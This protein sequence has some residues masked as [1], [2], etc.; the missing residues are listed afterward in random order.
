MFSML[1]IARFL[2]VFCLF[3]LYGEL[4]I[5]DSFTGVNVSMDVMV[6]EELKNSGNL[7]LEP[8][9]VTSIPLTSKI[10]EVYMVAN[11]HAVRYSHSVENTLN[12]YK[13]S[14]R[15]KVREFMPGEL[16]HM[17][18][19]IEHGS[20][21]GEDRNLFLSFRGEGAEILAIKGFE[22]ENWHL[23]GKPG[24]KTLIT[25]HRILPNVP[26]NYRAVVSFR[27]VIKED[28]FKITNQANQNIFLDDIVL[29]NSREAK[30]QD[31]SHA[32]Y[33]L[34]LKETSARLFYPGSTLST[35]TFFSASNIHQTD[36]YFFKPEFISPDGKV[37]NPDEIANPD[38]ISQK[39]S[40]N[41]KI[42]DPDFAKNK[43]VYYMRSLMIPPAIKKLGFGNWKFRVV[44]GIKGV[45]SVEKVV[46][47]R[48][49]QNSSP[50]VN[51]SHNSY[52]KPLK[53]SEEDGKIEALITY[54][55][56]KGIL[57]PV[58]ISK[59]PLKALKEKY[60]NVGVY[61]ILDELS[62]EDNYLLRKGKMYYILTNGEVSGFSPS[63]A[64]KIRLGVKIKER[65]N[66][67]I[68]ETSKFRGRTI[69]ST[70]SGMNIKETT[71]EGDYKF[72]VVLGNAISEFAFKI[73]EAIKSDVVEISSMWITD[74]FGNCREYEFPPIIA[75]IL[76]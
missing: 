39:K 71:L 4:A 6:A 45:K 40:S 23:K 20:E 74:I 33:H 32:V 25:L 18:I 61:D 11:F 75:N 70:S 27:G 49:L 63:K 46:P 10:S 42:N 1:N 3:T 29:S 73:P 67:R 48:I 19:L 76:E 65:L 15:G 24:S 35:M 59:I 50:D 56:S 58:L 64:A 36:R 28:S 37:Y 62:S 14:E 12:V 66:S 8:L 68:S 47:F 17:A 54:R 2:S 55:G 7:N 60:K 22:K 16:I 21:K 57:K 41:S 34:R 26:G 52:R 43:D 51:F 72:E 5:A 13:E 53:I 69:T 9:I 30:R 31:E 44:F 38:K